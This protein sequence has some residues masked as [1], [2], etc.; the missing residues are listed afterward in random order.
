M[1]D[2][3]AAQQWVTQLATHEKTG[4]VLPAGWK[5]SLQGVQGQT[6]NLFETIH[7]H[8][9]E[10]SRT[11]LAFFMNLGQMPHASGSRALGESQTDFF[12]LAVQATADYV[13]RQLTG[14]TVK[15][16]VNFNWEGVRR[17]PVVTVAN[18]QARKLTEVFQTL[19]QLAQA[20]LITPFPD[21]SQ[22]LAREMGLPQPP[23]TGAIGS[24]EARS[25]ARP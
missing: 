8:N 9:V 11:A 13:A 12:L 4:M 1:E 19:A 24:P 21:L 2:R 23:P 17:Y 10:I 15:R 18:L 20:G 16:L 6:R 22:Y 25:A 14:T 3:Q 5:F 7:H